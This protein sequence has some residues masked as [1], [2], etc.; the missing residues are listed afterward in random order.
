MSTQKTYIVIGTSAAGLAAVQK[1][2]QLDPLCRILCFSDEPELPYNKCFLADFLS[3]RAEIAGVYTKPVSFFQS[4]SVELYLGV[5]VLSIDRTNQSITCSNGLTYDYTALLLA[6][7]GVARKPSCRYQAGTYGLFSFHTLRDA[8]AVQASAMQ[9]KSVSSVVL[10]AGLTGLEVADAL[11]VQGHAVTVI[12][13]Q[14]RI[15]MRHLDE[16]GAAFITR[17]LQK[18]SVTLLIGKAVEELIS[19]DEGCIA[20]VRLSN[21]T[22]ILTKLVVAALGA[23][24]RL[25]LPEAAGLTIEQGAVVTDDVMRTSDPA[26]FAAGDVALVKN[27]LTGEKMRTALWPDA[28]SQGMHAAYAMVDQRRPYR[29]VVP[30]ATAT[31]F[32]TS[33]HSAGFLEASGDGWSE[34]IERT[35]EGYSK[36]I[37]DQQG[38]VKGF[39]CM[40]D[41]V[42]KTLSYKRS[43]VTGVPLE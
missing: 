33:F 27:V 19:D 13:Q 32:G 20:S 24:A 31:F 10:G 40:G 3:G 35:P 9:K 25:E 12:E 30:V 38:V 42:S 41:L 26:I 43:M 34:R 8:Q 5:R 2:R 28:V 4:L 37:L 29:G 21:G 7:G 22:T 11:R 15:L 23:T 36:V 1:I 39:V 16:E 17:C 14:S 18:H 6:V